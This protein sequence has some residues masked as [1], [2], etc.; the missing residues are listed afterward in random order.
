MTPQGTE[1]R[2][3][4]LRIW[5]PRAGAEERASVT[6]VAT[7][8]THA[9]R[10]LGQLCEW[11]SRRTAT[12]SSRGNETAGVTALRPGDSRSRDTSLRTES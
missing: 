11:L 10:N 7:G 8:A 2:A 5:M 4:L 12:D 1:Y 6:D 3:F 9:F